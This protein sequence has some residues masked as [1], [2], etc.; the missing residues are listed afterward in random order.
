MGFR[1][2]VQCIV[3][4]CLHTRLATDT[5]VLVKINDSII[6]RIQRLRWTDANARG[7][8]AMIAT[9]NGEKPSG[10]RELPFLHLFHPCAVH[11]HWYLMFRFAGRGARMAT[12][13]L[14]VIN[15]E[16]VLHS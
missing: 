13:A 14:S 5:T 10:I 9:H 2:D 4:T 15:N 11:T 6:P 3:R 1:V 16:S 12:D 8:R 7:I